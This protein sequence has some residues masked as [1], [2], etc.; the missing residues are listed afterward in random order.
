[1]RKRFFKP[2]AAMAVASV[3][4]FSCA[5][6]R[7]DMSDTTA[8]DTTTMSETETMAGDTE[9]TYDRDVVVDPSDTYRDIF[10][11]PTNPQPVDQMFEDIENTEQYDALALAR[12]T[13][14]LSAFVK[15]IERADMAQ[16]LQRVGEFTIFAPTNEAFAQVPK[17]QMEKLLMPNNK[18]LLM[19]VLQAHVLPSE[20]YSTQFTSASEIE[21]A[22]NRHLPVDVNTTTNR[23]VVGGAT[24][25]KPNIETSNG[26]MHIVDR[27]IIPR[28][29][30]VDDQ[31]R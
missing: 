18:A 17:D 16:D 26:V 30:A 4:L 1:M 31:M 3:T 10:A 11:D 29:D 15:L 22:D 5:S 27:V 13:P 19:K 9:T 21:L 25:V 8:M 12:M 6:S 23:I 24:I 20:V 2:I 7:D 14:N 28:E